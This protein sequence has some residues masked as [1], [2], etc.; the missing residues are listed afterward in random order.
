MKSLRG[1]QDTNHKTDVDFRD[2]FMTPCGKRVLED[3]ERLF[4]PDKLTTDNPHTTAIRVG[5]STPIRYI[6]RRIQH[7]MDGQSIR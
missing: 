6:K 4:N 5:E 1:Q 7:G 2:T 3:L